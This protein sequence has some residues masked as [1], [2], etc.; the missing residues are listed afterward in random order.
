MY[1]VTEK[2]KAMRLKL[3]AW[4]HSNGGIGSKEISEVEDKLTSLL[5]QPFTEATIGQKKGPYWKTK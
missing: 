5:G 2:I 4:A 1:Q 3:L